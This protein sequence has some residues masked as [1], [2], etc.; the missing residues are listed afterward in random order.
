M[1]SG[2]S[3]HNG[4]RNSTMTELDHSTIPP[5]PT[6]QTQS[7]DEDRVPRPVI[8]II[9]PSFIETTAPPLPAR[10]NPEHIPDSTLPVP[11]K[12]GG[13]QSKPNKHTEWERKGKVKEGMRRIWD[14]NDN[15]WKDIPINPDGNNGEGVG[16]G[17]TRI[18]LGRG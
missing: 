7:Q 14:E 4:K 12:K 8:K 5:I 17:R 10:P 6:Q 18:S 9:D 1:V 11:N 16:S 15:C 13:Y 3:G 2:I